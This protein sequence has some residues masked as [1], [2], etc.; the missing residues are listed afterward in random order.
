MEYDKDAPKPRTPERFSDLPW[1][2]INWCLHAL[3]LMFFL[4]TLHSCGAERNF[5]SISVSLMILEI[6]IV[7]GAL[8]GFWILRPEVKETARYEAAK[9]AEPE[10]RRAAEEWLESRFGTASSANDLQEMINKLEDGE[11]GNNG[12]G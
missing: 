6:V 10:A 9:A 1:N 2:K 4:L 12:V 11:G 5:D 8:G 3:W 7:G